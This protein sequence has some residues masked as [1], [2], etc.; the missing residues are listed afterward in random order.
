QTVIAEAVLDVAPADNY[1]GSPEVL[2]LENEYTFDLAIQPQQPVT[3]SES[4]F[5]LTVTRP[6]GEAVTLEP[7]MGSWAH[8]VAFDAERDGYAHLHPKFT[9]KE[10]DAAPE[11]AFTML[12]D[13][14][15]TYRLWAQVKID[16]VERFAPFAL[17]VR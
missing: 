13:K 11:L 14:P 16:G 7:V 15:G 6:D 10:K 9:G 8:L 12:T 2:V 1:V 3:T 5:A 17:E 4:Q